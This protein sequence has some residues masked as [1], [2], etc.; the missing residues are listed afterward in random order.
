MTLSAHGSKPILNGS[1]EGSNFVAY[2]DELQFHHQ[3]SCWT[4]YPQFTIDD[5]HI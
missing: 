3:I 2:V 5:L 1:S 4:M